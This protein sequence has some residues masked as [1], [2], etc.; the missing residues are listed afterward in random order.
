M[1]RISHR[2][3]RKAA[4][5]LYY[6]EEQAERIG[7]PIN[8]TTT[9]NFAV[10]GISP[11]EAGKVFQKL[12]NERFA[13]WCRRGSHKR[14]QPTYTFGFENTRDGLVYSDPD[15]DEHNTHV[16]WTLHIP[17]RLYE[18]F[19]A[20]LYEWLGEI[21]GRKDW[22]D[23]AL[24]V[25]PKTFDCKPANYPIKGASRAVAEQ[26]GVKPEKITP[27]GVVIGKRTGTSTNLG[28]SAR[29]ALDKACGINRLR[30]MKVGQDRARSR[31]TAP[32]HS[33]PSSHT[34]DHHAPF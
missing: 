29:R 2:V 10:L 26:Y 19:E 34:S 23:N 14:F 5:T 12:R 22:P 6:A 7:L 20:V 28:P 32:A 25:S 4:Q 30:N 15:G 16:H 9:I 11:R 24:R 27:Q 33:A 1:S 17:P 3:G 31:S 21:A 8:T 18:R 13:P